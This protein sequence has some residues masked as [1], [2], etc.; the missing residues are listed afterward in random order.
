MGRISRLWVHLSSGFWFL[1]SLIVVLMVGLAFALVELDILVGESARRRW[2]SLMPTDAGSAREMLSSISGSFATVAGVVFS[3]TIVALALAN[4]QY[5]SRVLG[6]FTRDKVNQGILGVMAGIFAY[7]LT[8]LLAINGDH[9]AMPSIAV[10]AAFF[11]ALGGAFALIFFIHHI[12]DG[13]QA[14]S[15]IASIAADTIK[16]VGQ[17]FTGV[18]SAPPARAGSGDDGKPWTNVPALKTG[19]IECVDI[20]ALAAFAAKRGALVRMDRSAGDFVIQGKPLISIRLPGPPDAKD[21][22]ALNQAHHIGR[23]RTVDHDPDFGIRQLVDMALKALS[24]GVNDTTTAVLCVDNLTAILAAASARAERPDVCGDDG[25]RTVIVRTPAFA[26]LLSKAFDQIRQ[27][28][29]GNVAVIT[30]L[31]NG[32]GILAPGISP[33]PRRDGLRRQFEEISGLAA[34]SIE[35]P[36]DRRDVE[37]HIRQVARTAGFDGLDAGNG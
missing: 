26:D 21:L 25:R 31:L 29:G 36:H 35:S 14:T 32:I 37:D 30:A 17:T 4:T 10:A 13:I 19:Y 3:I 33:G 28:A 24:P 20:V 15:I 12:V 8:V 9:A 27:N 16:A 23:F 34:R 7:C 2:P 11:F 1:P 22:A 5:S 18:P 6:A